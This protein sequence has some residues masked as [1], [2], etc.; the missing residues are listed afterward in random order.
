M[1]QATSIARSEFGATSPAVSVKRVGGA[2]LLIY[3]WWF[4]IYTDVHYCAAHYIGGGPIFRRITL[5]L[6]I[7]MLLIL[8][9]RGIVGGIYWPMV[10]WTA[11]HFATIFVS[12][13]R[14]L[15][16][17]G[18]KSTVFYLVAFTTTVAV[19]R[20]PSDALILC[21][22]LLLS[23][24]WYFIQGI[25][26]G[27]VRWHPE[28]GNP[29]AFGGFSAMGMGFAYYCGMAAKSKKWRYLGYGV[30][31]LG[32]VGVVAS[33]ARGAFLAAVV[34]AFAVWL[35]SPRKL[36]ALGAAAAGA[37]L[38]IASA[39][40][41]FP[42]GAFWA[43]MKTI[44]EGTSSGTGEGRWTV[45]TDVAWPVFLTS[46]IIGVGAH[47]TGAVGAMIIAPDEVGGRF[48]KN[49][50]RLYN[51]PLHSVYFQILAEEGA[52]GVL[53]W[54]WMAAD[55]FR[56]LSRMRTEPARAV[57]ARAVGGQVELAYMANALEV[58][59]V[60][61]LI[62]GIFYNQAYRHWFYTLILLA[63]LISETT[64]RQMLRAAQQPEMAAGSK[65]SVDLP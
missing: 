36:R 39:E 29:D 3:V 60:G 46:P 64:R 62:A 63:L 65:L 59:M 12:V 20:T 14:G 5:V 24:V 30:S 40:E 7:P 49:P 43:E 4:L 35:R 2:L 37:I 56:R 58:A 16:F 38:V 15:A 18:F 47:N 19:V 45:W 17:F 25:P 8:L 13:N 34:V 42:K 44:S 9:Q 1:S 26:N 52:V 53:L 50:G 31:V 54:M 48:A 51:H 11:L 23:F 10:L 22:M 32:A 55:F 6:L 27:L 41:I 57:W 21:R 28:L 61:F 33:F